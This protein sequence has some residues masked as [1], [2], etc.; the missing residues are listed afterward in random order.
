MN[1]ILKDTSSNGHERPWKQKKLSNLTYAAYLEV[2]KFKKANNVGQCGNVLSFAKTEDGLRLYQTWFCHSR[3]CPLCSWRRSI[4]NSYE[5][6]VILDKLYKDYPSVNFLFL[7]LTEKN[8]RFGELRDSLKTM[9]RSI[10]RLFKYKAVRRDLLGYARSTEI[11]VNRDDYTFHQHI[12]ILLAVKSSYFNRGHYLTQKD[13]SELWKKARK[14]DYLPVVNVKKVTA[15]KKDSSLIASAKEV[16]KYQVKDSDYIT[17]DE[18]SDLPIV[19]ELEHALA[20]SRQISFGGLMKI[21]RHELLL[22][23]KEDD[24]INADNSKVKDDIVGTVMYRWNN[25]VSNYVR[26]E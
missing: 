10:Y 13:W 19:D 18:K 22:D 4:K 14:I 24:L 26:W 8:S 5:M 12:H 6:R 20:G 21:I 17:D 16:A 9:N 11:T 7:T 3:L 2:L 1:K 25:K 23:Q 15:S